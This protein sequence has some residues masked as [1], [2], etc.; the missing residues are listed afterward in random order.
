[1]KV[2]IMKVKKYWKLLQVGYTLSKFQKKEEKA[3][4]KG[5][6]YLAEALCKEERRLEHEY[7][8]IA[9]SW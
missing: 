6:V 7:V 8:K 2:I 4:K 5:Y 9:S 3:R 1:M